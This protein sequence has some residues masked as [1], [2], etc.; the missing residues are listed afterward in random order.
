MVMFLAAATTAKLLM[1][2]E[3]AMAVAPVCTAIHSYVTEKK[4]MKH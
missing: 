2:A 4:A 1:A 3:I